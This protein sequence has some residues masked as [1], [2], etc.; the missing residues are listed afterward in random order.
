MISIGGLP[1]ICGLVEEHQDGYAMVQLPGGFQYEVL[2]EDLRSSSMLE[3]RAQ[4]ESF[5][6]E[7]SIL[8]GVYRLGNPQTKDDAIEAVL[9]FE[10]AECAV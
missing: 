6:R 2:L 10:F 8:V 5:D 1:V 3:R 9:D 7:L 4:L